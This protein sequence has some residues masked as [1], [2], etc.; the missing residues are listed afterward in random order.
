[1]PSYVELCKR[2]DPLTPDEA[3]WIGAEKAMSIAKAR[4][5]IRSSPETRQMSGWANGTTW[6]IEVFQS[7]RVEKIVNEALLWNIR[8]DPSSV[9]PTKEREI[10]PETVGAT[11]KWGTTIGS[12]RKKRS[13]REGRVE[14]STQAPLPKC[15][16]SVGTPSSTGSG[17]NVPCPQTQAQVFT[18]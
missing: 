17:A 1:M 5:N 3:L 10:K 12:K 15:E 13:L 8:R 18:I 7:S 11:R 4:E 9:A 16:P 14:S 2:D 6:P